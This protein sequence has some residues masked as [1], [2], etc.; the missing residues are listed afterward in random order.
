MHWEQD[1]V[2]TKCILI[3]NLTVEQYCVCRDFSQCLTVTVTISPITL[4][5][6]DNFGLETRA[7]KSSAAVIYDGVG[8]YGHMELVRC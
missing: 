4:N 5:L 1:L 2:Y 6:L 7:L 8:Y 3:G